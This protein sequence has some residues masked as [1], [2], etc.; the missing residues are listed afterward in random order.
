SIGGRL[1]ERYGIVAGSDNATGKGGLLAASSLRWSVYRP[2]SVRVPAV[3]PRPA[4]AIISVDTP[5]AGHLS[6]SRS[7]RGTRPP[8]PAW[9]CLYERAVAAAPST[10]PSFSSLM[11]G[12]LPIAHGVRKNYELL[13][14]GQ[15][16]LARLLEKA[17]YETA[18]FVSSYVL[19][20]ENSGLDLGFGLYD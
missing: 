13:D 1:L 5:R 8:R 2:V 11:T 19:S 16:T 17:G 20:A 14:P 3:R 7:D 18:A 10:A 9:A 15:W 6:P 4:I 12:R